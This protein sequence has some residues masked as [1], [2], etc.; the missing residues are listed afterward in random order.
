MTIEERLNAELV[1]AMKAHEQ[2]VLDCVRMVKSKLSEKRTSPG[3]TGGITDAVAQEVIDAYS[4]SLRKALGE[5]AAG[6]LTSGP[7]VDK[8]TFEIAF[9]AQYLPQKLDE[10]ATREL[11]QKTM[12]DQGLSGPSAVGRLMGA[13]MKGHKDEVD[14]ALVKRIA[15]ELLKPPA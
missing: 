14:S 13:I 6:G 12:A 11:V 4:R 3:F 15:E 1:R 8:Y 5:F 2:G 10:A 9:L 7:M